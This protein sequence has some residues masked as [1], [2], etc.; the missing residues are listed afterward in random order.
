MTKSK[1]IV[2]EY[3][4]RFCSVFASQLRRVS[5]PG[6][7]SIH[8]FRRSLNAGPPDQNFHRLQ[9]D[10]YLFLC[11][12]WR[13][14][15]LIRHTRE[16][17]KGLQPV[18]L[19]EYISLKKVCPSSS[20][21]RCEPNPSHLFPHPPEPIVLSRPSSPAV[22]PPPVTPPHDSID[23][24]NSTARLAV[25]LICTPS[26]ARPRRPRTAVA[27]HEVLSVTEVAEGLRRWSG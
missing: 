3:P 10:D 19:L 5:T 4:T 13:I 23:H 26:T 27:L 6:N 25:T 22:A 8:Y 17:V 11:G 1:G 2:T 14:L 15:R 16:E 24:G 12:D 7:N 21:R 18:C 20:W 9:D